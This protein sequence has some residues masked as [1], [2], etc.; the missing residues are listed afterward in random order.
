MIIYGSPIANINAPNGISQPKNALRARRAYA[1]AGVSIHFSTPKGCGPKRSTSTRTSAA[2]FISTCSPG[3]P[4]RN[5]TV[6]LISGSWL[7]SRI[8]SSFLRARIS[9]QTSAAILRR[10]RLRALDLALVAET[11]A[12]ISAVSSARRYGLVR[13]SDGLAAA[14]FSTRRSFS[15]TFVGEGALGIGVAVLRDAVP[16]EVDLHQR[17]HLARRARRT[18]LNCSR[19]MLPL[20]LAKDLR[21]RLAGV[22][23]GELVRLH[24]GVER[25]DQPRLVAHEALVHVA[26]E[27]Q[28][29]AAFPI[30]ER[31][32]AQHHARN[33]VL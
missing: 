33:Q 13:I 28:V 30:I 19:E 22:D 9:S 4:S 25:F 32:A 27:A 26:A 14:R 1:T 31:A 21:H 7:A 15:L 8:A 11:S 5:A 20:Q 16:Q 18:R 17:F 24:H 29:H 2:F 23:H 6:A 3:A 10:Q 12:A